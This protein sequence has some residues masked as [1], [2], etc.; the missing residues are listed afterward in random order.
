[1]TNGEEEKELYIKGLLTLIQLDM[2]HLA[3]K[4]LLRIQLI[5]STFMNMLRD[6]DLAEDLAFDLQSNPLI[7]TLFIIVYS[8]FSGKPK[9][10]FLLWL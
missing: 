2:P 1:L 9:W 7:L 8:L 3:P 6:P 10:K 4:R 5:K